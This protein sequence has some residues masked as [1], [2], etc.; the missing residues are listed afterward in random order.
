MCG[1]IGFLDPKL[2][3]IDREILLRMLGSQQ[4]RGPDY[5]ELWQEGE[6]ALGHNRLSIID[7]SE[8]GR[9]P[10]FNFDKSLA[11]VFNGEIYNFKEVKET[12][13]KKGYHFVSETDTEVVLNG[14]HAF[15]SSILQYI[16]GM[17][18]F[19]IYDR[20]ENSF[21]L[22]R[23]RFGKKPLFYYHDHERFIFAS[24]LQAIVQYPDLNLE[25]DTESLDLFLSLQYVPPP[26]SIYRNIKQLSASEYLMV[27]NAQLHI[28]KYY[29][30]KLKPELCKLSFEESKKIVQ[31][32]VTESV[33]KRM[34][35]DVPLGCFL[36]GGI[37]SSIVA[38][39]LAQQS[40]QA[41]TTISVG[42]EER[43]Y[44][45]LDKARTIAQKYK[46]NH[47]E[48]V[49]DINDA[50]NNVEN[51]ISYYAQPFGDSS[52]IPTFF[53]SKVAK[54]N[55][56]VALSGDGGDEVFAGYQ[57]YHLDK[58]MNRLQK[59]LPTQ[60]LQAGA[61]L[62]SKISPQQNVPI[63]KNW[64]LGLKRLAQVV[65]INPKAS[66]LRWGS[67]F[68]FAQ[69]TKLFGINYCANTDVAVDSLAT[70]FDSRTDIRDFMQR[71]QYTDLFTYPV[72]DY[73]VKT[74]IAAMRHSL[75]VR[76]PLLDYELVETVF[77][78][79]PQFL[80]KN[81]KGKHIFKETFA[82]LLTPEVLYG[83]K[84]GFGIPIAEWFRSYWLDILH[85]YLLSQSS[86]CKQ[87]F[88]MNYIYQLIYEHKRN[89]DDHSK[90][91]YLLL[92]LEVWNKKNRI[93][94]GFSR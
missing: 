85:D 64:R 44:S 37:D 60:L 23:D 86:F 43:E 15:G 80:C 81:G 94:N 87:Y 79:N 22:A 3:N 84:R 53:L 69:K 24:E 74:D 50:K 77:S 10:M 73:L 13:I 88:N 63:E 68:S 46:T 36:S 48:Y 25:I 67:Y 92:V 51:I 83:P 90:R 9:Q 12:L 54:Q 59:Y 35:A 75:E 39:L 56:T 78:L 16:N 89:I 4:H 61:N 33:K 38:A 28:E 65:E 1:I 49:L 14:Y 76:C 70:I 8:N 58:I 17:F 93:D 40:T 34:M 21:F 41:I 71:T 47:C 18:A 62:F 55:I 5:S 57:R 66:I 19:C 7:L 32:M 30:L 31:K 20:R 42:F 52:A 26:Y 72:G 91:L 11:I 27:Q 45:E 82:N 29:D 2:Y 6:V